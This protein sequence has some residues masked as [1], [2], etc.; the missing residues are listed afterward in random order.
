MRGTGLADGNT[1]ARLEERLWL[2]QKAVR[3]KFTCQST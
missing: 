1:N 3:K 2:P